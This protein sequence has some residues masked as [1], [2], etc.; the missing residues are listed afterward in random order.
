LDIRDILGE[1]DAKSTREILAALHEM[2][3]RP[4]AEWGKRKGLMSDV[5]LAMF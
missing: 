4:W 3:T 5:Q 2:E 1:D